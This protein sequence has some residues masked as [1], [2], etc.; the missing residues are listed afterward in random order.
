LAFHEQFAEDLALHAL[1]ALPPDEAANVGKHLEQCP[2]CRQEYLRLTA[3]AATLAL[4]V[5]GPAPPEHLQNDLMRRVYAEP[6][7]TN[8]L[9]SRVRWWSL[10]PVFSTA[11]LALFAILL[12]QENAD[13]RLE[14]TEQT[15]EIAQTR[16]LLHRATH[17]LAE[18]SSPDAIHATL[19]S[20]NQKPQPQCRIIYMR[21]SGTLVI[22]ANH[23][24][25]L[26]DKKAYELWIIPG[27]GS[28]PIPAGMLRPNANGDAS[29]AI[30]RVIGERTI[31]KAFAVTV[32]ADAGSDWPTSK[33]I[34]SGQ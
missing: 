27:D 32:E 22:A 2:E 10:A 30:H 3:D 9:Q 18:I 23:L 1:G 31:I 7:M 15:A 13:L 20:A 12:W 4:S 25:A 26:P 28:S 19:V 17:V 5:E 16:E 33:P 11:L 6:R 21:R 14:N 8:I 29:M 34:M 24:P